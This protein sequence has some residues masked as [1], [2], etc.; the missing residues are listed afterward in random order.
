MT[1]ATPTA[2][3]G[4]APS[5][6]RCVQCFEVI[7]PKARKCP[8]CHSPQQPRKL[9]TFAT[10]LKWVGGITAVISLV[11]GMDRVNDLYSS[12][13][14]R[15][16]TIEELVAAARLQEAARD[17]P[18][19]WSLLQEALELDASARA[20]RD[21]QGP[22]AMVW[23][24]DIRVTG[25]QT[26]SELVDPLLPVLYRGAA[27]K[28]KTLAADMLA[29]IGWANYLKRN[30]GIRGVEIDETFERAL[31]LDP[32]N[33]YG[34]V[35]WAYWVLHNGNLRDYGE[36]AIDKARRHIAAA[37]ASGRDRQYVL[38]M[39]FSGLDGSPHKGSSEEMLRMA[40]QLSQTNEG[41]PSGLMRS[42]HSLY[43][44][45]TR[46]LDRRGQA[47]LNELMEILP[48]EKLLATFNWILDGMVVGK[49]FA[50]ADL[51]GN[52]YIVGRLHEA[53]GNRARALAIYR[54]LLDHPGVHKGYRD[55][56]LLPTIE[57]LENDGG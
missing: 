12:W 10:V 57:R 6:R 48:P 1:K 40:H 50:A 51:S 3:S 39:A 20:V 29:H 41:L 15:A 5:E 34:N 44:P 25:D 56:V 43:E 26:F 53:A 9:H 4:A 7:H 37:L 30:D 11:I 55:N 31:A 16:A 35:H 47:R 27:N 22:F 46:G 54:D 18:G 36:A 32:T 17:Y 33:T 21:Y 24:R 8:H 2:K 13:R 38:E 14:E 28:D 42:L 49:P 45:I 19:G 52:R 23:L